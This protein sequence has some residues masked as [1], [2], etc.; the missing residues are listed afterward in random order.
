MQ[1]SR[2]IARKRLRPCAEKTAGSS[3]ATTLSPRRLAIVV[4]ASIP[5][6]AFQTPRC[7]SVRAMM[8][9]MMPPGTKVSTRLSRDGSALAV[10]IRHGKISARS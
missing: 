6:G 7:T 4:T 9:A 10:A 2:T 3:L 8:P 1:L 5:A